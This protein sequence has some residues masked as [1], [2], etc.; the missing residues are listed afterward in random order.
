MNWKDVGSLLLDKAPKLA[1]RLMTGKA[2]TAGKLIANFIGVKGKPDAV[3][4]AIEAN[5][6][7]IVQLSNNEAE[8]EQAY[9]EDIQHARSI[10]SADGRKDPFQYG[11][12][13]VVTIGTFWI[14]YVLMNNL[15][16]DTPKEVLA[17]ISMIAG[18]IV[19]KFSS[20]VDYFFGSSKS[21]SDKTA[22]LG[23]V[24]D[25]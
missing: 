12:A 8:L 20:V 3:Y 18:Q 15:F 4:K 6:D 23:S 22:L 19:N 1:V 24:T 16:V 17:L 25:E 2:K 7:I 13:I 5:P 21:S 14:L 11:L 10:F 9:L